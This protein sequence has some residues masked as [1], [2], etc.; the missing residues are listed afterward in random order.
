MS[1]KSGGAFDGGVGPLS[2]LVS[3]VLKLDT[4]AYA[5]S[6][7]ISTIDAELLFTGDY[8]R[9]GD[10]LVISQFGESLVV[11]DYF[12][13]GNGGN[14]IAPNGA[15][16]SY[17][18]VSALAG[19]ASPAQYVQSGEPAAGLIK[20]GEVIK[21]EG[22]ASN[23]QLDGVTNQLSIG[24]PVYQGDVV[25][26]G[27]ASSLGI[28]FSDGTIFSMAASGK[29]VLNEL[30]YNPGDG[31]NNSMVFN[32]VQ[33]SFVFVTGAIAPTGSMKM[34]TP[35]ATMGIRGTTPSL[36]IDMEKGI[37]EF[38]VLQD[39]TAT[40]EP[41][42]TGWYVLI[43]Q[44][45]N[46]IAT[47]KDS[48]S[49]WLVASLY[50]DPVLVE[51]SGADF[52]ADIDAQEE[53]A[54]LFSSVF[55][56]EASLDS[57]N[58]FTQVAFNAPN[59]PDNTDGSQDGDSGGVGGDGPQGDDGI[60]DKDDAPIAGDDAFEIDEENDLS[61]VNVIEGSD[62][63]PDGF[64]LTVTHVNG[65]PLTFGIDGLASGFLPS[66]ALLVINKTGDITYNANDVYDFL[67]VG[68]S[69]EDTFN[70]TVNDNAP[71]GFSATANV[72]ITVHGRNDSP[73]IT[74]IAT[75]K[76]DDVFTEAGDTGNTTTTRTA[77]G[78]VTFSDKD[79]SDT[80]LAT[81][82]VQ[83]AI[84][85]QDGGTTVA[86]APIGSLALVQ[87]TD[88]SISGAVLTFDAVTGDPI[89]IGPSTGDVGWLYS[90]LEHELDFLGE[91]ETL[92]IT[93]PITVDDLNGITL[94]DGT[95]EVSTV[96]Q[97]I[98]I[99]ITGT[100]DAPTITPVVVEGTVSDVAEDS[101]T[102]PDVDDGDKAAFGSFD[103]FDADLTD[104]PTASEVTK[105]VTW[106]AADGVTE[107][108]LSPTQLAAFEAAFK[109]TPDGVSGANTNNGTIDW[110][111]IIAEADL[112]FL[113]DGESVVAIFTVTVTDDEGVEVKQDI[114]VNIGVAND[115]PF[116]TSA[117]GVE[118]IDQGTI[119]EIADNAAGEISD[120]HSETG[121]ID[122]SDVDITDTHTLTSTPDAGNPTDVAVTF[123]I[124]QPT[125]TDA[126]T[127]GTFGWQF[128]VA[129]AA[130]DF[131]QAGETRVYNYTLTVEDGNGGTDDRI[132]TVTITGAND[133]PV[134]T[135]AVGV[136]EIDQGTITE[137]ADNTAGENADTHT[138]TGTIDFGD[139]DLLDTHTLTH[140]A[141][142]ANP[143]DLPS[144][145]FTITQP[146][147][148]N[149]TTTGIFGWEFKVDDVDL[150]FLAEGETRVFEYTLTVDDGNGGTDDRVV[151]VTI[152]GSND[153]PT[154]VAA[155]TDD[156]GAVTELADGA[157]SPDELTSDL[158]DMGTITFA[159]VDLT[160]T[161]TA[162]VTGRSVTAG[163][164]LLPTG[165]TELGTLS[166]DPVNDVADTVEWTFTVNDGAV[167]F[168]AE[169]ESIE[170]EFIVTIDDGNTDNPTVTQVVT[171]VINGTNDAAVIAAQ[172]VPP[173]GAVVEDDADP[174]LTDSGSIGFTDVDLLDSH[175]VTSV[176]FKESDHPSGSTTQLGD[177]VSAIVGTQ[178]DGTGVGGIID[179][180]YEV[181]NSDV[182]FLAEGQTITETYTI[183][184][185]DGVTGDEVEREI[186]VTITGI[187]D[188]PEI[189][190]QTDVDHTFSE[191]D[192]A[193]S[194]L[195][196]FDIRDVDV[197]NVVTVTDIT[198]GTTGNAS[199]APADLLALFTA[200]LGA[201][202]IDGSST[203]GTI[204][205]TFDSAAGD[206]DYLPAGGSITISYTVEFSDN[207][208]PPGTET[209]VVDIT[210][211]GTNDVPTL[212]SFA[213]PIDT[214]DEDNQVEIT[215]A[216]LNTQ[217]NEAD[218][219]GTVDGYVV[220]AVTTGTLLIGASAATATAFVAGSNDTI[221]ATNKAFWTPAE[222]ANGTLD[223]FTAV[224]QDDTGAVSATPIQA[225]VTVNPVNDAPDVGGPI[226]A[227][228]TEG[229]GPSVVSDPLANAS[230]V[231][232]DTLAIVNLPASLPAGVSFGGNHGSVT[233]PSTINITNANNITLAN[234]E[235]I[236]DLD[237]D[238]TNND[239]LPVNDITD[240]SGPAGSDAGQ[241]I[242]YE[243]TTG[244]FWTAATGLDPDSGL[245]YSK[246]RLNDGDIG[247]GNT[248]SGTYAIAN[249]SATPITLDFGGTTTVGSIAI[250]YGYDHRD[251]GT[252]TLKDSSGTVLGVWDV[253]GTSAHS[254][255]AGAHILWLTF[256]QPVNTSSLVLE[257]T[258]SD[259]SST[260]SF[261]EIQVF[262]PQFTLDP[263]DPAYQS[264]GDTDSQVVTLNYDVF[265][266]T[267]TTA[268]SI[269]WTVDGVNDAPVV[270]AGATLNYAHN[271]GNSTSNGAQ[272]IDGSVTI[273]DVD[274]MMMV[275]ATVSI[276]QNF[277][278]GGDILGFV[279]Q[280]GISGVYD[281][282]TGILT[283]TGVADIADYQTALQSVT[284][285]NNS[286]DPV[287]ADREVSFVVNDG[288]DDS[289]VGT[290]TVVVPELTT[291]TASVATPN[292][293]G[294]P[295]D[296]II[297][298]DAGDND[299]NGGDGNDIII[300]GE[301]VDLLTGGAGADQFV[302]LATTD[303]SFEVDQILD[304]DIT[305][306]VINIEELVSA[307]FDP[308][309]PETEITF[310]QSGGPG[311]DLFM[312]VNGTQVA[313]VSGIAFN[314]TIDVIYNSSME[315]VQVQ[316]QMSSGM[317]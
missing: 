211:N 194:T 244:D 281:N 234:F 221:D 289:N 266:G 275:G 43:D 123:N 50:K 173:E 16:L 147:T 250:Y 260:I 10:S 90:V 155:S 24:D 44:F 130:L 84:W 298:G 304:F 242:T 154:I 62:V 317:M 183:T 162:S 232:G 282:T 30:V 31:E 45:G 59:A 178:T 11:E 301:G 302:L 14:L 40:G 152:T 37:G 107:L 169:G 205:W 28:S 128:D 170:Q 268:H 140:V 271:V 141:D 74:D 145:M 273:S 53:I 158:M 219:D 261:R 163:G 248:S 175:T 300:G 257:Y 51:K 124:T 114:T 1:G 258:T 230:D 241:L 7:N 88:V 20:I 70:Y 189:T 313:S 132:V 252:Y 139:V 195:G 138:E 190:A 297:L 164:S 38:S 218:V 47:V 122:F 58:T 254:T 274:N 93:I 203:T 137:I 127:S 23:Q 15:F 101:D 296:N 4:G 196:S 316:V 119:T 157:T 144:V 198:V 83:T 76:L 22:T 146:T 228:A 176:T 12:A 213:A 52:L 208:T 42:E 307:G 303:A 293:V 284:F 39:P 246:E 265:D 223:A 3:D 236:P 148:T 174:I 115:E 215:F 187:N 299:L 206:F 237:G 60:G 182:Q 72:T 202:I 29:M 21:L 310:D 89:P 79:V 27:P 151:T 41:G 239:A 235:F 166:L 210:I 192:A 63:D 109:I 179:W 212:T 305:N 272:V 188:V 280:N 288:T 69:D 54:S 295:E 104:R 6:A 225:Q 227:A 135:S 98:T 224:A 126:T 165:V 294:G 102:T 180:D 277:D 86:L 118:E 270:T 153:A 276:T 92:E 17:E 75:T 116:I 240:K 106:L 108:T 315:A 34:E 18:V 149:G 214:V 26:T 247:A 201:A 48:G 290:S 220:Q 249:A 233:P 61:G 49:K 133:E 65:N 33:G 131:L 197:T 159:D 80:H 263:T 207:N 286:A 125:T 308:S 142:A 112:D 97:N 36:T 103:F 94:D 238:H 199:G 110:E 186:E 81:Q 209:Q 287:T 167:D 96:T 306:D 231:D 226:A 229:G 134:I 120:T 56:D 117:I 312:N 13:E 314:D 64:P 95:S 256:D 57:S 193:L 87:P 67:G 121:T 262:G 283:L 309:N 292:L 191:G 222:D 105:S 243:V 251:N 46:I 9:E 2:S 73:V 278:S 77:M 82:G 5:D 66:G 150:D 217:G 55:G 19:P 259:P 291:L 32:L 185:S 100:N 111:Y 85:T 216:E 160:D 113:S 200:E 184:L 68:D 269:E 8:S 172:P 255:N 245:P 171:I 143:T 35:V 99:L 181:A 279:N 177:I 285:I 25:N 91:G 136:E 71:G 264:L 267:D 78:N 253:S 161:H 129:D 204:D 156:A 311:T 168:L